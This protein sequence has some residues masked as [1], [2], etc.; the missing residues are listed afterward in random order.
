MVIVYSQ[1][2]NKKTKQDVRGG[3]LLY[4]AESIEFIKLSFV[5]SSNGV[6]TCNY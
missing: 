6:H 3:K 2:K 5:G 4:N 1:N